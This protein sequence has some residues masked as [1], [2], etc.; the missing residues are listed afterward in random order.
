MKTKKMKSKNI[1]FQTTG[2]LY[3]LV[4]SKKQFHLFKWSKKDFTDVQ[5]ITKYVFNENV[6][7][8]RFFFFNLFF[9]NNINFRYYSGSVYF[10]TKAECV[11]M[12]LIS[13]TSEAEK[14]VEVKNATIDFPETK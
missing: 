4:N 14:G 3:I 9:E 11:Q 1:I 5:F 6:T 8:L 12:L 13:D 7:N 2:D 10:S